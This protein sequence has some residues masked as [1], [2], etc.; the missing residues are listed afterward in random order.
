MQ[1][2]TVIPIFGEDL[3]VEQRREVKSRVQVSTVTRQCKE[4]LEGVLACESVQ[5]QVN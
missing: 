5:P 2:E 1:D 3:I 4:L